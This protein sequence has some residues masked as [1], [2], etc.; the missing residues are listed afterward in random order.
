MGINNKVSAE[1][2]RYFILKE[3]LD[4]G[5]V[6]LAIAESFFWSKNDVLDVKFETF[7]VKDNVLSK[8]VIDGSDINLND[9]HCF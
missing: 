1:S 6:I 9:Y 7:I 4:Y 8:Y 5:D 2:N 3:D